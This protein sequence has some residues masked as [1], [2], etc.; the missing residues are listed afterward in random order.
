MSA[1]VAEEPTET[2]ER[3]A[4]PKPQAVFM[5]R[6]AELCLVMEKDPYV[7]T[8]SGDK[9]YGVGKRLNFVEGRFVV[10]L[11]EET[12]LIDRDVEVS[13]QAVL[14]FLEGSAE[15]K[16]RPHKMFGNKEEGFWRHEEAAPLPTK[17]ELEAVV[18][19]AE[20]SDLEGLDALIEAERDGWARPQVLELAE[21][22]YERVLAR[23]SE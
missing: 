1:A 11:D 6:R 17:V 2:E 4:P 5:S 8:V 12:M 10:P 3:V 22:T 21:G 13:C 20:E 19:M 14:D 23:V 18:R 15:R 16:V 9:D 7:I